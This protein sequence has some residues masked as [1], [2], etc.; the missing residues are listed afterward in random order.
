MAKGGALPPAFAKVARNGTPRLG[1]IAG[2]IGAALIAG[3]G[4]YESIVRIYSPW[5]MGSI[6]LI[7]LSAI[8]LRLAE[9]ELPRPWKMP[10]FPWTAIFAC[11]IQAALIVVVV[12]DDPGSAVWTALVAFAPLPVYLAF[13]KAWRPALAKG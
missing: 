12:W 8:R 13:A 5:N 3:T 4:S 10:L 6:L 1:L 11:A 2:V 7:C 9:P